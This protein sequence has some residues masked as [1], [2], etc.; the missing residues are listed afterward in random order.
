MSNELTLFIRQS[1]VYIY[2]FLVFEKCVYL[3]KN[4]MNKS[5]VSLFFVSNCVSNCL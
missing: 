4:Q 3:N 5:F 1:I 2:Y